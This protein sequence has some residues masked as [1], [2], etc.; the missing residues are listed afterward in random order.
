MKYPALFQIDTISTETI[1]LWTLPVHCSAGSPTL[2]KISLISPLPGSNMKRQI[3]PATTIGLVATDAKLTKPQAKRL[4]IAASGGKSKGLRLA[5]AIFDGDM[6]FAASTGRRPLRDAAP[7]MIEL[8]AL[9]SDCLAR[10]IARG[11]HAATALPFR[12]A[13]PSWRDR[14]DGA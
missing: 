6:V 5:H 7:E 2:L 10:A 12:G 13:L 4:A 8:C 11:V 1:A 14:F 9:A 3:T